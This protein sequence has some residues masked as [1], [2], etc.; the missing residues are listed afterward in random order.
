M[1]V[2]Q[3]YLFG[4]T[5]ALAVGPIALLIMNTGVRHGFRP[6]V[7]AATGASLADALYGVLA[8]SIGAGVA[9]W[10][11]AHRRIFM[12]VSCGVL[13]VI[14]LNLLRGAWRMRRA[15]LPGQSLSLSRGI[16][17]TFLLTAV[18]PMTLVGFLAFTGQLAPINNWLEVPVRALA[19]AFGSWTIGAGMAGGAALLHRSF[20]SPR[21]IAGLNALSGLGILGF[22]LFGLV[23]AIA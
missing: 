23:K 4:V 3:A 6:G 7:A 20:Q 14:A 18:N 5:M 11:E 10:L 1:A 2:L 19:V 21:L 12:T 13:A 8:M 16:I 17:G 22:A 9:P 15:D